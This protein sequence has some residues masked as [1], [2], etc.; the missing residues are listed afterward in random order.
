MAHFTTLVVVEP[1]T[2]NIGAK[3]EELMMPYCSGIEVEPYKYYLEPETLAKAVNYLNSFPQESLKKTTNLFFGEETNDPEKLAKVM[4]AW[5]E[6]EI[7]GR[8]EKGE[9]II[10]SVNP[11]G[12]WDSYIILESEDKGQL[13]F[14][15][16]AEEEKLLI[17]FPC[18]VREISDL[19]PEAIVTPD[20][21]WHEQGQWAIRGKRQEMSEDDRNWMQEVKEINS[22]FPDYLAVGLDCHI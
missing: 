10:R 7:S 6:D 14:Y 15:C 9:Y 12:K 5:F 11:N 20:G 13:S 3:V 22:L 16:K 19:I 8:D 1:S 17:Y 18:K 4:L 21:V 2:T